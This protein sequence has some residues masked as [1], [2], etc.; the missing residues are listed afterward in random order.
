MDSLKA[1]YLVCYHNR[2]LNAFFDTVLKFDRLD[3]HAVRTIRNYIGADCAI[4]SVTRLDDDDSGDEA[5][6][7]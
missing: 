6:G 3:Y 4:V 1:K 2:A 5:W 7:Q